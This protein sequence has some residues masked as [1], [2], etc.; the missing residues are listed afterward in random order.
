MRFAGTRLV[1]SVQVNL[2]GV[3]IDSIQGCLVWLN[4][5]LFACGTIDIDVLHGLH[6][7]WQAQE[8]R[9]G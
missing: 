5:A 9:S 4:L 1:L 7:H 3:D 6:H 8:R 2:G